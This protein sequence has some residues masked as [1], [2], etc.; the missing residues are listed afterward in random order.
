VKT[1]GVLGG[2]G[3]QATMDFEARVHAVSQ[4]LI[5]QAANRG[6]PPMIVYY[7]RHPPFV[8]DETSH[9]IF[10]LQPDPHLAAALGQ[11]GKMAD[12]LVCPSNAPHMMRDVIER[13][14]GRQILSMID[15]TVEEIRKRGWRQVGVVGFG[16][17][18]VYKVPLEQLDLVCE[19]LPGEPGGLR[20]RL[21][22]AI[23]RVM[24]GQTRPEDKALAVEAVD[25]LWARGVDGVILG[26]TEIPLLLGDDAER[27]DMVN[28]AQLLAEAAVRFAM[29]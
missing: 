15:Q 26:C 4:R 1:I 19:T 12:F 2:V 10:P 29:D 28:P 7:H 14:A 17:P 21:D 20:D 24:A 8:V 27:D 9:P 18:K 22:D 23:L 3:P 11:L 16:E 13:F 5:P 6:Y 25:L